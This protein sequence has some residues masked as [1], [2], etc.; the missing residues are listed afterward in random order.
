MEKLITFLVSDNI[1]YVIAALLILFLY[2][3]HGEE[4]IRTIH[5]NCSNDKLIWI[6][7]ILSIIILLISVLINILM[8]LD[9]IEVK[10]E[11]SI[12]I[13][14]YNLSNDKEKQRSSL[15][16]ILYNSLSEKFKKSNADEVGV[17]T[18]DNIIPANDIKKQEE[19]IFDIKKRRNIKEGIFIYGIYNENETLQKILL[20]QSKDLD[21]IKKF[22]LDKLIIY[23]PNLQK[24]DLTTT[25]QNVEA[26][27][28][29]L[30]NY[31]IH[32]YNEAIKA[33]NKI[34]TIFIGKENDALLKPIYYIFLGNSHV[35]NKD[36]T[37]GLTYYRKALR[38]TEDSGL[39]KL[40]E[41]NL[42]TVNAYN[43]KMTIYGYVKSRLK[44]TPIIG[45]EVC[46]HNETVKTDSKGYF[47]MEVDSIPFYTMTVKFEKYK[48][49]ID[50]KFEFS[51]YKDRKDIYLDRL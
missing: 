37:N 13:G 42:Q 11:F 4:L 40:L 46:V 43:K 50:L 7:L 3:K 22:R 21:S 17:Y 29:A 45:A 1:V 26:F 14:N 23:N 31:Y 34:D 19:I 33:F 32:N 12:Q 41:K 24:Y 25:R 39:Q 47:R 35:L 48:D 27:T 9:R 30:T 20:L 51:K 8:N 15:S 10:E 18:F 36:L 44:Q 6:R 2:I 5:K 16:N 49:F 28:I 38:N